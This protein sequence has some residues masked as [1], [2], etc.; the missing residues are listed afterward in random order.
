MSTTIDLG[1]S[2]RGDGKGVVRPVQAGSVE[3]QPHQVAIN[4]VASGL[5]GTDLHYISNEKVGL[6]HEGEC[7]WRAGD[8][9]RV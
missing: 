5:C 4:I 7:D 2:F 6:G 9:C 8:E 1:K 3:L